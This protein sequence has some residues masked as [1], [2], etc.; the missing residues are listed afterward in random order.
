VLE[1]YSQCGSLQPRQRSVCWTLIGFL[2]FE[3]NSCILLLSER[4]VK[5]LKSLEPKSSSPAVG[6][7][8]RKTQLSKSFESFKEWRDDHDTGGDSACVLPSLHSDSSASAT[9]ADMSRLSLSEPE[10]SAAS[11]MSE[12]AT[13]A[14]FRGRTRH[15]SETGTTRRMIGENWLLQED[16]NYTQHKVS[17]SLEA[18]MEL[19]VSFKE[20]DIE[21]NDEG[22]VKPGVRARVVDHSLPGAVGTVVLRSPSTELLE[23]G[24][25]L[26]KIVKS[27]QIR[28]EADSEAAVAKS[29]P[30][31]LGLGQALQEVVRSNQ[32]RTQAVD[33]EGDSFQDLLQKTKEQVESLRYADV[34]LKEIEEERNAVEEEAADGEG[35]AAASA[36]AA[37]AAA[38]SNT[39]FDSLLT[40]TDIIDDAADAVF[41]R[42]MEAVGDVDDDDDD[43]ESWSPTTSSTSSS[44]LSSGRGAEENSDY[45]SDPDGQ[46]AF[47][48]RH[49]VYAAD[50]SNSHSLC[51]GN[52]APSQESIIKSLNRERVAALADQIGL[53]HG[54]R[55]CLELEVARLQLGV[56][57]FRHRSID[58]D[59]GCEGDDDD[60]D[61][62]DSTTDGEDGG[63]G[64]GP[65]GENSFSGPSLT[66]SENDG[67]TD[68]D[69]DS[70]LSADE[71]DSE[72]S[73]EGAHDLNGDRSDAVVEDGND[74]MRRPYTFNSSSSSSS[75]TS[76]SD[77]GREEFD[78]RR[79]GN[80]GQRRGMAAA[81][82]G[83][84]LPARRRDPDDWFFFNVEEEYAS[85][86]Q[87]VREN[88]DQAKFENSTDSD[89]TTGDEEEED[90][91]NQETAPRS[92][93]GAASAPIAVTATE[94]FE[95]GR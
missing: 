95:M 48:L 69:D 86:R 88:V 89:T 2:E 41:N 75:S 21:E 26:D 80:R 9:A 61:D 55:L 87:Y 85:I 42:I 74:V 5:I 13:T 38:D 47:S 92:V 28:R 12:A 72:Y 81:S 59:R 77:G 6:S 27:N 7:R 79:P 1:G 30:E 93:S 54:L 35:S 67:D 17:R 44:S 71:V 53:P 20:D 33:V 22:V 14:P 63:D 24:Q 70:Q 25:E 34:L 57:V 23:I 3:R 66:L 60:D 65:W 43:D 8:W 19:E 62:S 15:G 10:L 18:G 4:K 64:N 36:S 90:K 52:V 91:R 39:L 29:N 73:N 31:E 49:A 58:C 45:D 94:K 82:N 83:P 11:S 37:A 76:G 40:E 32:I 56:A 78:I 50:F 84:Q 46:E 51:S 68:S 16:P